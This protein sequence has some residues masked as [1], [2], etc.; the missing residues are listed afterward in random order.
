[1]DFHALYA[2]FIHFLTF[3]SFLSEQLKWKHMVGRI[4]EFYVFHISTQ[5][6]RRMFKEPSELRQHNHLSPKFM[7]CIIPSVWVGLLTF[8]LDELLYEG[9]SAIIVKCRL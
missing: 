8:F 7:L 2:F 1:M 5:I 3:L 4:R 9:Q 6:V